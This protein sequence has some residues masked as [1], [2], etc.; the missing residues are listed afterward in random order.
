MLFLILFILSLELQK[1]VSSLLV[2]IPRSTNFQIDSISLF[3]FRIILG[4]YLGLT[5]QGHSMKS[6]EILYLTYT[7]RS[8]GV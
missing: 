6:R 4:R 5:A 1:D 8:K 3:S 7:E 2:F